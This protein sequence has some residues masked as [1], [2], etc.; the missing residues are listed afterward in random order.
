[1]TRDEP[2]RLG[3][4]LHQVVRAL[5]P[6][7]GPAAAPAA[8]M[9]GVFGRWEEAVGEALAL[10][11]QPVKLDGTT[12]VVKVDDPAWATQLKFLEGTLRKRLLE[13]AGATDRAHRSARRPLIEGLAGSGG[14][15]WPN[16]GRGVVRGPR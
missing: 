3:D 15:R 4:S 16:R 7:T 14:C 8:V 11:V 1:M 10:H 13:V 6:E 12:L 2:I 9:G 5:R